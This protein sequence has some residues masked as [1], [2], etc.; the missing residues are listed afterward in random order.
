[1]KYYFAETCS[2]YD[3]DTCSCVRAF[4][5]ELKKDD[6]VVIDYNDHFITARIKEP[7]DELK[8]LTGR[9][10]YHNALTKVEIAEYLRGKEAEVNRAML[11]REMEDLSKEVKMVEQM[12]K[13]AA[14]GLLTDGQ[15]ELI[16]CVWAFAC[17]TQDKR[18][19]A[20]SCAIL[21]TSRGKAGRDPYKCAFSCAHRKLLSIARFQLF[22]RKM[23]TISSFCT[24]TPR[25]CAH[26]CAQRHPRAH[27]CAHELSETS[28]L[29]AF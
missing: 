14:H 6:I 11:L 18:I 15:A 20:L 21:A 23:R 25:L 17:W 12:K 4:E 28:F 22:H 10:D 2:T 3:D 9:Y 1:M 8:I 7:C 19:C 26:S 5:G 27:E 16:S 29:S 13:C 24:H